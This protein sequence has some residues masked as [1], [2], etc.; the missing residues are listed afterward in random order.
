[1]DS[2]KYTQFLDKNNAIQRIVFAIVL[3]RNNFT[4]Q[5]INDIITNYDFANDLLDLQT[6]LIYMNKATNYTIEWAEKEQDT[7]FNLKKELNQDATMKEKLEIINIEKT[8]R[9]DLDYVIGNR[10]M[11][12]IRNIKRMT[13]IKLILQGKTYDEIVQQLQ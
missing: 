3:L 7:I 13:A 2:V 5:N 10:S 11:P 12:N 4:P 1:M 9:D 8:I 6:I